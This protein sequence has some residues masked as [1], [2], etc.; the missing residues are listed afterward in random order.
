MSSLMTV[1][2]GDVSSV[3]RVWFAMSSLCVTA[4]PADRSNLMTTIEADRK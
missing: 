2:K 1:V 4:R 3:H